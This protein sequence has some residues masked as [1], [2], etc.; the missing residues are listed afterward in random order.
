MR[1][2]TKV[3]PG[4]VAL[5]DVDF[6]VEVGEVLGL[7]GE[8]GAGKSTLMNILDGSLQP[9]SGEIFYKGDQVNITS[10]HIAQQ[11][12][13][14]MVHQELKLFPDLTV[15]E[16]ILFGKQSNNKFFIDW[17]KLFERADMTLNRLSVTFSSKSRVK[18]LSIAQQQQVE[19]AKA[20]SQNCEI[21]ILDEPTAS[22]TMDETDVLFKV[23]KSL[24]NEKMSVIY[25]SHR[26]EEVFRICDRVTVL[27][28]GKKIDTLTCK[29]TSQDEIV[30]LMIGDIN[31]LDKAGD[32]RSAKSEEVVL[33]AENITIKDKLENV[34]FKLH[35]GEI[36]GLA[37]LVGSGR[38][39][40]LQALAGAARFESGQV[41]VKGH[42]VSTKSPGD[43]IDAGIALMPED[44]KKQGLV[45]NMSVKHNIAFGNLK[46][47]YRFGFLHQLYEEQVAKNM[48]DEL[49]I[50]VDSSNKLVVLLSGGNQQKVVFAK[51]LFA[52]TDIL[53]LDEPT[54]G[55]DVGAKEEVFKFIHALAD[56]GKSVIFVSSE[57]E[58]VVRVSDRILVL[59]DKKIVKELPLG[60][61][62]NVLL[63]YATGISVA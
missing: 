52:N 45:L 54:R 28:D 7:V 35:K 57:L 63:Q 9:E 40:L 18:D 12:G 21:L 20:L 51:W 29:T 56:K 19:I 17:P 15:A 31:I 24:V 41:F 26:L 30:K 36:L 13:I 58:E 62:I 43:A 42:E 55:I 46:G 22:L 59:R 33:S 61:D 16:N 6:S 10:P 50:K 44:R 14:R 49:G 5:D 4:T 27:R 34:S 37:G 3:F 47:F 60:T 39:E 25:I 32:S 11:L 38:T 8:N 48:I 1:H 2:I 23:I 53:L